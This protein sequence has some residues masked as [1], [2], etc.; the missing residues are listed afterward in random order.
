ME[1]QDARSA[2]AVYFD[3]L[4][5]SIDVSIKMRT[6][7]LNIQLRFERNAIANLNHTQDRDLLFHTLSSWQELSTHSPVGIDNFFTI[8][9][10]YLGI[11]LK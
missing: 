2:K 4:P 3:A 8:G 11:D 1:P 6:Q 7:V 10:R 9:I 5:F